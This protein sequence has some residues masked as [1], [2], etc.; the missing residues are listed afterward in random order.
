[1]EYHFKVFERDIDLLLVRL[2]SENHP[3]CELFYQFISPKPTTVQVRKVEQ[4]SYG[5]FGESDLELY[6][7]ADGKAVV[8]LIEDKV[9]A[10]KQEKQPERY[11][12]RKS[13]YAD[14]EVHVIL[15]APKSYLETSQANGY[16][17]RV[18]YEE[19]M[20]FFDEREFDYHLLKKAC[21][22]KKNEKIIDERVTAYWK[23]YREFCHSYNERTGA[24]LRLIENVKERTSQGQW[25][26]FRTAFPK[27]HI[28]HKTDRG[29][30]AWEISKQAKNIDQI[31]N[32]LK[33]PL[34]WANVGQSK[35]IYIATAN[36]SL[37][38][39]IDGLGV[40]PMTEEFDAKA[41]NLE[42]IFDQ[43]RRL[44]DFATVLKEQGYSF[45]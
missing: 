23:H 44:S 40:L 5:P 17:N 20:N 25:L 22:K 32:Q 6:L 7:D 34:A 38:F 12:E 36:N 2:F 24:N 11:T 3:A 13:T 8:L 19:I 1:M 26:E 18:S 42:Y 41:Q 29:F 28:T 16:S 10:P 30:I 45:P 35:K 31:A 15:T 37:A 14:T 43:I 33:S 4:S 39:R 9:N 21:E 27:Y